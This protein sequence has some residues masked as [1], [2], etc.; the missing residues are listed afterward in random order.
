MSLR[1]KL[2]RQIEELIGALD[3]LNVRYALIGGL[4]LAPHHVIRATQD[5]DLLI[6]AADATAADQELS[7]LGYRCL[8]RSE[9]AAN[10]ARA[11][12]RVDVLYARRP[13][14]L[15]LLD[16]AREL[17]TAL[18]PLRVVSAEGLIGFKLQAFVNNPRRT[19]DLED[20]RAL[21]RANGDTLDRVELRNYF[22]LFGRSAL[23]EEIL[24]DLSPS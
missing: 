2:G 7:R 18:G 4:A 3:R 17:T 21:I 15:R 10:Y 5:I 14:A 9:D 19:Q 20:I 13:A 11:D 24:R 22:Q 1:S 23:L 12:E 6:G 8:H 16:G